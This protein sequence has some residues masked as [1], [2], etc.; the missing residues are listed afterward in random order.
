MT[1][2]EYVDCG[3]FV[4]LLIYHD[5]HGLLVFIIDKE[6]AERVKRHK[7][8]IQKCTHSDSP[9]PKFYARTSDSSSILLH[10]FVVDAEKGEVVDHVN[11]NTFDTRKENLRRTTYSINNFNARLRRKNRSGFTGV[12][13][14]KHI[15]MWHAY[16]HKDKK[17]YNLGYFKTKEE[18]VE[19]RK[20]AEIKFYG[21][22]R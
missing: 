6:D 2:N 8:V 18:A 14:A 12:F 21:S 7:W 13:F 19:A 20:A 15:N 16:I 11:K 9:F 22:N 10:R 4:N 3:S 1:E 17:R 5:K